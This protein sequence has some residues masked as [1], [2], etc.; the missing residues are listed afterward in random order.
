MDF[1]GTYLAFDK[2]SFPTAPDATHPN[3]LVVLQCAGLYGPNC[4]TPG[5]TPDPRW[6]HKY[7]ITWA[8]PWKLDLSVQWRY[9][10]QVK[11]DVNS[12]NADVNGGNPPSFIDGTIPAFSYIDLAASWRVRDNITLRGGVNNVFDKEPPALDTNFYPL[13]PGSGNTFANM[14][15]PLGRTIFINLTA[16]Y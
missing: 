15:D 7:R 9:I 12:G 6:R 2:F 13:A 16:K 11:A 1:V 5:G 8:T 10:Q 4:S 3:G 14:Y